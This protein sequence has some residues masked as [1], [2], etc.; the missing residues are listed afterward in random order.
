MEGIA[1]RGG[2]IDGIVA[3]ARGTPNP[4]RI[5]VQEGLLSALSPENPLVLMLD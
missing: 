5:E 4:V 1:S 3:R 2:G